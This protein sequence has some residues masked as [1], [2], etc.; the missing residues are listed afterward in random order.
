MTDN[1]GTDSDGIDT[2]ASAI[3][4]GGDSGESNSN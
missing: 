4:G 1:D 3:S 2:G